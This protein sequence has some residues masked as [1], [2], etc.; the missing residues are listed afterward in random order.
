MLTA[1][2]V[3]HV[4]EDAGPSSLPRWCSGMGNRCMS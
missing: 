4:I 1:L 2:P 3:V